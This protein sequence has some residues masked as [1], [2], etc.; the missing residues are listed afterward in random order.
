[1]GM[2]DLKTTPFVSHHEELGA[3]IVPFAGWR[4]PVQYEGILKEHR[5]VRSKIGLFDVSHMGRL[6]IRGPK[7]LAFLQYI[8][9]NDVSSLE[10]G[11]VQ[12]STICNERGGILD[13]VT[14]YRYPDRFLVVVNASNTDKIIAWMNDHR[15]DGVE[16]IDR[17]VEMAQLALQGPASQAFLQEKTS[18][19]LETIGFY[20]FE[21]GRVTGA[22]S[23]V[24][25]T[26]YT[27][28]DGFEIYFSAGD[29]DPIWVALT[30]TGDVVPCGL[31]ARDILR[32]EVRYCLYG[33]DIDEST[34]P[35][36]AGLS[37]LVKFDKGD[38][39]G[40]DALIEAK[41]RGIQR[42]LAGFALRGKGIPRP[43][44]VL[45][46]GSREVSKVASGAFSPCLDAG[47]GTAYL[48]TGVDRVGTP[49]EV[50]IRGNRA[51]AEVVKAPFYRE[52][53]RR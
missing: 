10:A 42:K 3:R 44:Y 34:T 16:I 36:E 28:E 31:G 41:E 22:A 18:I 37:W 23:T 39:I 29:S 19:E 24:S 7:A 26:G 5:A 8:T 53:S 20:Q 49:I 2:S 40:R 6:E 30:E 13:D 50:L 32:L 45:Y 35:L 51:P 9:T 11:M 15:M 38:F 43:G 4:M 17:T 33:N 48:P 1:M 52:G 21:E 27:G 47:I 12:Y 14:V 46:H 25:R